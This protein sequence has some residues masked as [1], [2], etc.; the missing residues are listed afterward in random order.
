QICRFCLTY[1]F[2]TENVREP[3]QQEYRELPGLIRKCVDETQMVKGED[4]A[5]RRLLLF[6]EAAGILNAERQ[7]LA[8]SGVPEEEVLQILE[9][10]EKE[11][12]EMQITRE[13]V[14]KLREVLL[15]DLEEYR[16]NLHRAY[17]N[18]GK[19]SESLRK[20]EE[21]RSE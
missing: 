17:E 12:G 1:V 18:A 19:H 5:Y 8:W 3:E 15:E 20:Q 6:R 7:G 14:L 21:R 13:K 11:A 2:N 16:V 9:D 10:M 4:T